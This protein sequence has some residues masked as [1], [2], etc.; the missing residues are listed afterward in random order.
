MPR[1]VFRPQAQAEL[2]EAQA[3]YDGLVPGLGLEFAIAVDAAA[4]GIMRFPLA[5]PV[6]HGEA[7]KAVLRRFP[8]ALIYIVEGS[9]I[10]VLACYHHRRD[11]K[12]WRAR[13]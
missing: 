7:R 12:G 6:V 9:D 10:V 4:A 3:W 5:Y 13:A 2:R 11:P 1:L 8:Y